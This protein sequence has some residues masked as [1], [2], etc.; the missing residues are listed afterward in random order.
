MNRADICPLLLHVKRLIERSIDGQWP[1]ERFRTHATDAV[2]L[3]CLGCPHARWKGQ[4]EGHCGLADPSAETAR[5]DS[6]KAAGDAA[7]KEPGAHHVEAL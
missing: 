3:A 2:H 6:A 7:Q 5:D 4:G 1:F